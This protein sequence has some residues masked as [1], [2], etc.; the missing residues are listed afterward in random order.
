MRQLLLC[1]ALAGGL[2]AVS[3]HQVT[4]QTL[5]L[6]DDATMT[7]VSG[8]AG[9][10]TYIGFLAEKDSSDE[11]AGQRTAVYAALFRPSTDGIV[12]DESGLDPS[13]AAALSKFLTKFS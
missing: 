10:Q 8:R 4:A 3:A 9:A 13:I 7:S 2:T 11:V 12:K 6:A 1:G 5:T